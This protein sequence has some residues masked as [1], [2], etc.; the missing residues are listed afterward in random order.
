MDAKKVLITGG[1]GFLGYHIT[2]E[3]LKRNTEIILYDSFLNF[4]APLDSNYAPNLEYRL[5]A[6][7][8]K[9]QIIRGD[10]RD[11]GSF[12]KVLSETK[13]EI[14]IH[15]AAIP[16]TWASNQY[17]EEA[18]QINLNG[19]INILECLRNTNSLKRFVFISSSCVYGDF[20]YEPADESHLVNPIDV[21]GATK[22]SG[23]LL[24]KAF[25]SRFGLEYTIVRPSAVYGPTDCNRRVTQVLI[26]N[27]MTGKPLILHNGGLDRV[28]FTHVKDTASG[29]VLAAI[30]EQ[31]KNETF[32]ITRGEGRSIN[33]LAAILGERFPEIQFVEKPQDER[34]PNRGAL[35]I[36]KAA[37][38]L[39]Y[40]P[41]YDL[42][43]GINEYV[44]FMSSHLNLNKR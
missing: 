44:D 12:A 21:Y 31:A 9:V 14:I 7:R 32:N 17:S 35:D 16:L 3:L 5:N 18:V 40:V 24:T 15:L 36:T 22:L 11:K 28:D 13:P 1:A 20:S 29:I 38:V 4:I 10:V 23:E 43:K 8:G 2:N 34:R 27:A 41:Q 25:G 37:S 6:L 33:D 19:T 42:K 39:G 30:S 26:E